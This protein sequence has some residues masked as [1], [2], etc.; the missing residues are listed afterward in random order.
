MDKLMV[1]C[2]MPSNVKDSMDVNASIIVLNTGI[3]PVSV[4]GELAEGRF[5][6]FLRDNKTDLEIV[7]DRKVGGKY[8]DYSGRCFIDPAQQIDTTDN[9]KRI[10]L[11]RKTRLSIIFTLIADIHLPPGSI[12]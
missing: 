4:Y 2:V 5:N 3:S 8:Q 12:E 11:D 6:N 1:K 9:L 7:V 10:I